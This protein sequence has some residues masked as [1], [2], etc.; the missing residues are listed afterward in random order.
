QAP[1][2]PG[3]GMHGVHGVQRDPERADG[4]LEH[5]GISQVELEALFLEQFAGLTGLLA[6]GI[7]QVDVR[8]A[9]KAVF[10]IPLAFA[11]AH[12]NKFMHD[13]NHPKVEILCPFYN[14]RILSFF[15]RHFQDTTWT[16]FQTRTTSFSYSSPL[17]PASC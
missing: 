8:P 12:Q 9:R 5:R 1:A 11:V 13:K 10:K 3:G 15:Q 4:A 16:F 7:G 17:R 6:P 14:P 2:E